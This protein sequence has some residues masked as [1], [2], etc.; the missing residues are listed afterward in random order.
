MTNWKLIKTLNMLILGIAGL[1][2]LAPE[3]VLLIPALTDTL[4]DSVPF[5]KWSVILAGGL[6]YVA[7]SFNQMLNM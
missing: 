1:S 5:L 7:Y 3:G 4:I 2:L 6:G